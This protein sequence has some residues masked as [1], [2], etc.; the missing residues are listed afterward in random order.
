MSHYR[1]VDT[2]IWNDAKF[3]ALSEQAKY[4]FLFLLTHPF[5]TALGAMRASTGGLA[6]ELKWHRKHFENI[7]TEL[8]TE[9]FV[10]YDPKSCFLMIKNFIKY[11]HP[12]NPNVVKSWEGVLE[13]LP[14][15]KLKN[16]LI[17]QTTEYIT[18][19]FSE[20][21][22]KALPKPFTEGLPKPFPKGMPKQ[23]HRA[24]NNNIT[25]VEIDINNSAREEKIEITENKFCEKIFALPA[26][27]SDYIITTNMMNDLKNK[28]PSIDVLLELEKINEWLIANKVFLSHLRLYEKINTWLGDKQKN[29]AEIKKFKDNGVG[30][31][32][33]QG[34]NGNSRKQPSAFNR[35]ISP[36]VQ[37]IGE[38]YQ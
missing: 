27:T 11:N 19:H 12:D 28:F 30:H 13:Y 35:A 10:L 23:E 15:C 38:R 36:D 29:G 34:N 24:L 22:A 32:S 1:K 7:F 21:F 17:Q 6:D 31:A 33:N 18:A 14:E 2:R 9:N 25:L 16:N 3:N 5:L 8:S 37:L 26:K 4:L 20:A